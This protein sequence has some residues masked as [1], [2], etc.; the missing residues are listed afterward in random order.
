MICLFGDKAVFERRK[1]CR[2][3]AA[4]IYSNMKKRT[5]E[6][7]DFKGGAMLDVLL[8]CCCC[9][10]NLAIFTE[11]E[12]TCISNIQ[13]LSFVMTSLGLNNTSMIDCQCDVT[14]AHLLLLT[15]SNMHL[16]NKHIQNSCYTCDTTQL[17]HT[18]MV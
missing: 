3:V 7:M 6:N 5:P 14:M 12:H 9:F 13:L 2:D 1:W 8:K 4:C 17:L 15:S 10:L 18:A 16:E 11:Q